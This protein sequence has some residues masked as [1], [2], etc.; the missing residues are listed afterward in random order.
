MSKEI[1]IS[2]A[3][4]SEEHREWVRLLASHLRFIGYQVRIDEDVSYGDSLN[5]FMRVITEADH[6]LAIVD[7]NYVS[8]ADGM[9]DSGV[10]VENRWIQSVIDQRPEGWM[11]PL[12][13]R[14]IDCTLPNWLSSKKPKGFNFNSNFV[15]G[16]VFGAEQIEDLWR[17]L[18]GLPA[19][20]QHAITPATALER[21]A[22]VERIDMLRDPGNWACPQLEGQISF[23]FSDAPRSEFKLG[24]GRYDFVLK[25]SS[26]SQNRIYVVQDP[27]NAIGMLPPDFVDEDVQNFVR[28]GRLVTPSEGE[29]VVLQNDQGCLCVVRIDSVQE[30]VSGEQYRPASVTFTYRILTD[31]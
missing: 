10:A 13:I 20:R 14:N 30:E 12:F 24:H 15:S 9:P 16:D 26:M 5:G 1:F 18:E 31:L 28:P 27:V 11:A 3:W 23:D 4:T 22:R 29:W 7:E 17:W 19:D 2:Y 21:S 8:R 6:V 25:V